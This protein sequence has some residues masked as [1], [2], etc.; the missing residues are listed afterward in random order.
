MKDEKSQN[1]S[2]GIQFIAHNKNNRY[3]KG[4]KQIPYV[5]RYGQPCRVELTRMNLPPDL[6]N[7]FQSEEELEE[8]MA[9]ATIITAPQTAAARSCQKVTTTTVAQATVV[10]C[11][12]IHCQTKKRKAAAPKIENSNYQ[13]GQDELKVI[14]RR[15]RNEEMLIELGLGETGK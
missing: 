2:W 6:L 12:L 3:H 9:Q 15:K 8:V 7:P 13:P 10:E 14:Q 4:I 11:Q 5:L 1:W